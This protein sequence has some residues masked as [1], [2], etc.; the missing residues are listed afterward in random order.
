MVCAEKLSCFQLHK[1]NARIKTRLTKNTKWMLKMEIVLLEYTGIKPPKSTIDSEDQC[2][3]WKEYENK[4]K[5]LSRTLWSVLEK[6]SKKYQGN[7]LVFSTIKIISLNVLA[8][9]YWNNTKRITYNATLEWTNKIIKNIQ[10]LHFEKLKNKPMNE[11]F[12]FVPLNL[13]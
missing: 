5:I 9:C 10:S 13:C 11:I 12:T 1:I 4:L 7:K 2:K 3:K 8:N 6:K